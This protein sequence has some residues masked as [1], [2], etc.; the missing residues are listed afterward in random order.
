MKSKTTDQRYI[1]VD[2][3]TTGLSPR[4]GD[5]VIEIAAVAVKNNQPAEEFHT[6]IDT[7]VHIPWQVQRIHGITDEMVRGKPKPHEVYPSLSEFIGDGILV[8]HNAKFDM[9]FL[10]NEFALVDL[11]LKNRSHCT[12]ELSRKHLPHLPSHRLESVAR[13]LLG[14]LPEDTRLHRALAD[15]RLTAQIWI[16]LNSGLISNPSSIGE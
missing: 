9:G 4:R 15:A 2:T 3:E 6:L 10:R 1:V 7:G 16:R 13:H 5:R 11:K 8:A 12:V 14:N